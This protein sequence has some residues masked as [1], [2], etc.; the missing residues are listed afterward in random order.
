LRR[1][2]WTVIAVALVWSAPLAAT[3][4][5]E[6]LTS[7]AF[8]AR[9][10]AKAL[11]QIADA[12]TALAAILARTP[13]DR[14]ALKMRAMALGYR[15]KLMRSRSDALAARK[16]FDALVDADPHDPEAL[17]AIG[18]WHID[19]VSQL[20]GLIARAALGADKR[21]GLSALDRSVALGGKRAFFTGL[22][23]L[24]RASLDPGDAQVRPLAEA[25]LR[26]ATPTAL[27]IF[28]Q[29]A[30]TA[31][32]V[33]VRANDRKATQALAKLWLPLGRVAR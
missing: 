2:W 4:P 9:D 24:L 6:T 25:T 21:S 16:A 32:L 27:D 5:R 13:G 19:A 14:E 22:A 1:H 33:P 31:L 7:A 18:S 26:N 17:A 15:A 3:T 23:A 10:K 28:M 30:A 29:R 8:Q 12:Q 20:G 11:A